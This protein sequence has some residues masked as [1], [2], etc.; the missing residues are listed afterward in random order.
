MADEVLGNVYEILTIVAIHDHTNV[1]QKGEKLF[2]NEHP[3]GVAIEPDITIGKDKDSPRYLLLVS[4]T[5]AESA[6]H[7]KFWRN[8]GEFV[9]ARLALGSSV[10]VTNVVFDSGQ[11]RKLALASASLF[12]GFVEADRTAYGKDLLRLADQITKKIDHGRVPKDNRVEFVRRYFKMNPLDSKILKLFAKEL[13]SI[14]D[15]SSKSRSGW[16][17]AFK[18]VQKSRPTPR[19]P[20]AI[21]TSVRRGLGRLLPIDTESELRTIIKAAKARKAVKLPSYFGVLGLSTRS[22]RG[23]LITD[24]EIIGLVKKLSEDEIVAIWKVTKLASDSVRQACNSISLVADFPKMHKFVIDN[25]SRLA[26]GKSLTR[27]FKD[28][29]DNP[30]VIAGRRIGLGNPARYG[31][32]LFDYLMTVIKAHS[33]KQQGYGYTPLDRES[34]TRLGTGIGPHLSLFVSREKNLR[35]D[36]LGAFSTS[37]STRIAAIGLSWVRRA[38][39]AIETFYLRALFEDKIYKSSKLDPLKALL[40]EAVSALCPIHNN[41]TPTYLTSFAGVGVATTEAIYVKDTIIVWQSASDKGVGHKMKELCGRI[42]MLRVTTS[43]AGKPVENQKVKKAILVIDGTWTDTQIKRLVE[44]GFDA[45][46]YPNEMDA[47]VK[48]II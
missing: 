26:S 21:S 13:H 30:D 36:L 38:N 11:K 8:V 42:G 41:R 25:F 1:I 29:Y 22:I 39:L 31:V 10:S 47:L 33:G 40:V 44:C 34:N 12:D 24:D 5:N 4:H 23:E 18:N 9:D 3:K 2:W 20:R 27:A 17:G 7:H 35:A 19:I 28:C 45:V 48:A 14:L 15:K 43:S 32:W 37:I 46:F 6:S 16:Y